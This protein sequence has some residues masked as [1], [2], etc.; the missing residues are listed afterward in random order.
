MAIIFLVLAFSQPFTGNVGDSTSGTDS[1]ISIYVDNSNSMSAKGFNGELLSQAKENAKGIVSQFPV[2]QKFI[3]VSNELNGIQERTLNQ[4]DA[5]Y[6][7]DQIDYTPIQRNLNTI[8]NWQREISNKE[9]SNDHKLNKFNYILLSDFQKDFFTLK[10]IQE[11]QN[12]LYNII[13]FVPQNKS[14]CYVDSVWFD[15]PIHR[16]DEE[17]EL[18]FRIVNRSPDKIINLEV[19]IHTE[20][21]QKDLFVDIP[22][23]KKV[24]SSIQI[25][26][27]KEGH[28]FGEI[29]IRDQMMYWDDLFYFSYTIEPSNKILLINSDNH[30][31]Y[32]S[33]AFATEPFLNVEN[34]DQKAVNRNLFKNKNLIV[35]NGIEEISSG[36][37][38]DIV[39]F[40][41]MGGSVFIVPG[42]NI[43]KASVN[44]LFQKLNLPLI[45]DKRTVNL[46]ASKIS[47]K[48]PFF[49]NVFEES[50][51]SLNLPFY[52]EIYNCNYKNSS[53]IPLIY[54]RDDSPVFFKTFDKAFALYSELSLESG[55][56]INKSIF[57][58]ICLR[59]A[60]LA[61]RNNRLYTNIGQNQLIPITSSYSS[62]IPIKI[63]NKQTEFIPKIVQ[64][65]SYKFI[66]LSGSEA[67]EKLKDGNYSIFSDKE[68]GSLSLNINRKESSVELVSTESIKNAFKASKIKRIEVD[69]FSK[70]FDISKINLNLPQEYW[71]ICI[72][73]VLISIVSEIF[74]SKFWKN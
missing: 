54:L 46:N 70:D 22:S 10:N 16:I 41:K 44:L 42:Q 27:T 53:A 21:F 5:L 40:S 14:N 61:K 73:I 50:D 26:N 19:S 31:Q 63:K 13:Q 7:I 33:N 34:V 48:D 20:N 2:N 49:K 25:R 52:K 15:S 18:F 64:N 30:E 3:I 9:K 1:L 37:T 23:E 38:S 58:V 62:E 71:R 55:N 69:Q 8:V 67:I 56:L 28:V 57:P 59:I 35:L 11:D 47:F 17:N 29:E 60:E 24:T 36:L 65:G 6:E 45:T 39:S 43:N 51:A 32:V 72:F 66:D 74:I 12:S 4:K 68:I